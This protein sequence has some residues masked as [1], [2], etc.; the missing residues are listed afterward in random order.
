MRFW[1]IFGSGTEEFGAQLR[2][3]YASF[4]N[5]LTTNNE[6]LRM[7]TEL[8][9]VLVGGKEL[10]LEEVKSLT[11]AL[12][13]NVETMVRDLNILADGH[14]RELQSKIEKIAAGIDDE[15]RQ[16]H[17]VPIT[18]LCIPLEDIV[19]EQADAVGGKTSNL[20]EVRNRIGLPVPQ[21]FAVTSFAYRSFVEGSGIQKRLEECWNRIDLE[22]RTGLSR[23][24]A[25]MMRLV[26]EAPMPQSVEEEIALAA[27][28]L[29]RKARGKARVSVRSSAIGEDG[30][31]TFAGLYTTFL[32][33]PLEQILRRYREVIASKFNRR[34]LFYMRT[35]GF[36]ESDIAMSVGCFLMV[37]AV[38]AG[39][40]YSLDPNDSARNKMLISAV[41]G[42]GKP[43]VDGSV[44]PDTY[45]VSRL[46]ARGILEIRAATKEKRIIPA[47]DEGLVE[48][49]VPVEMRNQPCLTEDQITKLVEY[50]R[51]LETHYRSPQDVEWVL[52]RSG[53]LYILQTRSLR[54]A[55]LSAH[56]RLSSSDTAEHRI[57][58][59]GGRTAAPGAGCGPVVH[60]E[61]DEDL[62][63][64][65]EGGVL[66]AR[67]NSP[68]FV[69]VMT[70]AA[71]I[72][73]DVGSS[74]GHMASLS[75]EYHVPTI[76][77]AG[78]ATEL[79]EGIEVTVDATDLKVFAGR[80]EE[81][82]VKEFQSPRL[83][84][85]LPSF[86]LLE[87]VVGRVARLN[88]TDPSK[89]AFRA[90]NCRTYH[91]IA[92]FCHEMAI[93]EMFNLNDYRKLSDKGL[94]FRLDSDIPLGIYIIDLGGGLDPAAQ[95]G[96]VKPEQIL[97]IPMQALFK[98]MSTPGI[99]WG[100]AR[101]IDLKG[102]LSVLAN[103][104]YDSSKGERELGDNSYAILSSNY[105]NFGSRLGYHF[106]TLDSVCGENLN[107]NYIL[108]RFKGGAADIERRVRRTR[109][110]GEILA[111]YRFNIDQKE[112]L[113]HAW[114]K[115]LPV[116]STKDLLAMVGRLIGCARQLDV[117][118]DAEAT[119]ERCEK[120]FINGEYDFFDFKGEKNP[121]SG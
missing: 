73:T 68:R 115:K 15:Y 79:P 23:I 82:M 105:L 26:R 108:F 119:L 112:D 9:G 110:V 81:I 30:R 22:D 5:L 74:T 90:K 83:R 62:R 76:V 64:F 7:I 61:S 59:E 40:A 11:A 58:L 24:S 48:E 57:V 54:I 67:Q 116:N 20:G 70:R 49:P 16:V 8:E 34:A 92:R 1:K 10:S 6:I 69:E 101:P 121:G 60:A 31:L 99:R 117:V 94:A 97:S 107:D 33:I 36:N 41:W 91:D 66:V 118:M 51:A 46:P 12:K 89:N 52:D 88:L 28:D 44:T 35:H 75:R 120:A 13:A 114:V 14:Y 25:E 2:H 95:G 17:G 27:H 78:R 93:W 106:T 37:D 56:P 102:F 4:R 3:K 45:V 85:D 103:T 50:L 55:D 43:V 100:G 42:L 80:V 63:V 53:R 38:A 86:A 98:G 96:V 77:D 39:V 111:H 47:P 32:N 71:A 29:Y 19:R 65:P 104:M 72:L 87:R 18:R 84:S 109:F 21:G 113:L